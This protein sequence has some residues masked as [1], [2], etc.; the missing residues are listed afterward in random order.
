MEVG[1]AFLHSA[2]RVIDAASIE[3]HGGA[4]FHAIGGKSH[5]AQLLGDAMT[6]GLGDATAGHLH[7]SDMH[8][9][10]EKCAGCE[11]HGFGFKFHAHGG[12]DA[13]HCIAVEEQLCH[14]ILPHP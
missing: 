13:Y 11:H 9:P 2:E 8:Q 7:R 14:R 12:L 4:G 10:I 3:A 1:V 6:C 5:S